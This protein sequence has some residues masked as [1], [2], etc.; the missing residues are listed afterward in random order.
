M[1]PARGPQTVVD[2]SYIEHVLAILKFRKSN[3]ISSG[4]GLVPTIKQWL[5]ELS[6]LQALSALHCVF[7]GVSMAMLQLA[8]CIKFQ[9]GSNKNLKLGMAFGRRT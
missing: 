2:H 1:K 5:Q 7:T 3:H 6:A 4:R 8:C 9:F